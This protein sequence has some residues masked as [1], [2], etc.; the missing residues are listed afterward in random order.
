M[1]FAVEI[2]STMKSTR[3]GGSMSMTWTAL[4][5]SVRGN[6]PRWLSLLLSLGVCKKQLLNELTIQYNQDRK[7]PRISEDFGCLLLA[8]RDHKDGELIL[9]AML[10]PS[11][12][13]G[14]TFPSTPPT[15][16]SSSSSSSSPAL[17]VAGGHGGGTPPTYEELVR[18]TEMV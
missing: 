10:T 7:A 16:S 17:A 12:P 2:L 6:E 18:C 3:P 13:G 11:P 1:R 4:L 9:G 5:N 8:I 14:T 15:S